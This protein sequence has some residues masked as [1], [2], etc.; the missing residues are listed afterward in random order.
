MHTT[1][2]RSIEVTT[3]AGGPGEP[4]SFAVRSATHE[5]LTFSWYVPPHYGSPLRGYLLH[6]NDG[7]DEG[8]SLVG[9]DANAVELDLEPGDNCEQL[10]AAT[11][12]AGPA[13][14]SRLSFIAT[15]LLG[16]R[17]FNV[18]ILA[19]NEVGSSPYGACACATPL[20]DP[21]CATDRPAHTYAPPDAP[22]GP[23]QN[24][25]PVLDQE[26]SRQLFVT[27]SRP[28]SHYL[29]V[30]ETELIINDVPFPLLTSAGQD[31]P[32]ELDD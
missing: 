17:S 10:V 15:G 1:A 4:V 12:A 28:F 8:S 14:G 26:K 19:C 27:W 29:P 24:A 11:A 30:L 6:L 25:D 5:S 23:S 21:G 9:I 20:C 13:E 22:D 7:T 3:P 18:S 31:A 2:H 16:G 32:A